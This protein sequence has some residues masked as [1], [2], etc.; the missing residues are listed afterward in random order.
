MPRALH[1]P[2]DRVPGL[3]LRTPDR[4]LG[5]APGLR[6][7]AQGGECRRLLGV[8]GGGRLIED[9]QATDIVSIVQRR[10]GLLLQL[11]PELMSGAAPRPGHALV[12]APRS[13]V[14][15]P[16]CRSRSLELG[17]GVVELTGI[18]QRHPFLQGWSVRISSGNHGLQA[19]DAIR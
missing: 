7:L 2:L 5:G 15:A 10:A 8:E 18:Q 11:R 6:S 16:A 9:L 13:P 14:H 1:R 3:P 19:L 12:R 17:D 4:L